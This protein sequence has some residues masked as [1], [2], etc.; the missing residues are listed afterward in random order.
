MESGPSPADSR[1]LDARRARDDQ[2]ETFDR[3]F[4][5]LIH[6]RLKGQIRMLELRQEA[7]LRLTEHGGAHHMKKMAVSCK[8]PD[9]FGS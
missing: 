1:E 8:S 6:T 4:L 7:L 5:G 2:I 3:I 9:M